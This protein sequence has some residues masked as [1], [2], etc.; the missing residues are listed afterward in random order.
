MTFLAG[1][2]LAG[3]A[4]TG[5][6]V[7]IHFIIRRKRKLVRWGAMQFL[8]GT[9]PRFRQRLLKL[10]ELLV[11]LLRILAITAL[12]LAFAQPLMQ[13][14]ILAR[15]AGETFLIIDAS[16]STQRLASGAATAFAEEI[17]T[18]GKALAALGERDTVRILVASD[19]PRWLT[20]A[21]LEAT[22]G[23]RDALQSMLRALKP[24]DGSSDMVLAMAEALQ[25]PPAE[26]RNSR[27]IVI[28]SD[29]TERPWHAADVTRWHAIQKAVTEASLPT[30]IDVAAA[31]PPNPETLAN[32]AI[33][34]LIA[35]HDTIAIG[36]AVLLTAEVRNVGAHSSA[37]NE[38]VW[39][40][41]GNEAGRTPLPPLASG[42]STT[43]E[44]SMPCGDAGS[45]VARAGIS[46][47]DDLLADNAA[48]VAIRTL[49]QI[50]IL[51]VD[52]ARRPNSADISETGFFLAALGHLPGVREPAKAQAAFRPTIIAPS[53]LASQT[54]DPFFCIVIADAEKTDLPD[55]TRL[56]THVAKGGGLW[57]ALGDRTNTERFNEVFPP[58]A[59]GLSPVQLGRITNEVP[60][61]AP[62]WRVLPP[63][64]PH[65]ATMLLGDTKQ[66]DIDKARVWRHHTVV[67]PI[68]ANLGVLLAL[69]THA[70]LVIEQAFGQGRVFIQ[71][72]PL[73]RTWNN[74]PILQAYVPMVRDFIWRLV[75]G[76][77][78]RR[79][80]AA[81]ETLRVMA[82]SGV[83][84]PFQVKLPDGQ[85]FAGTTDRG[86]VRFSGTFLPGI[87]QV[88]REKQA[89]EL[90]SVPRLPDESDLKPLSDT[91]R[92]F[93]S[94][95]GVAFG[96]AS[97]A[98]ATEPA[99][100]R[101]RKSIA[102][103]LLACALAFFILEAIFTL[104]FAR[105]RKVRHKAVVL[106][107][108]TMR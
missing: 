61:T 55:A 106:T 36:D 108:V 89:I 85:T 28:I 43:L 76:K 83:D 2:F 22:P 71:M 45:H 12:V 3:L 32:L 33:S 35:D 5:V 38:V 86:Q 10:N 84:A 73:D 102:P 62:G 72:T 59:T 97:V 101:E 31:S 21:P 98:S 91:T 79:N 18:A 53:E 96:D 99:A 42:V 64:E 67:E 30:V 34:R 58:S 49:D 95:H 103:A 6:P 69:E 90:F 87:Y 51:V 40:L 13:S 56:A 16:L 4:L 100:V 75:D 23:N 81:G 77:V 1:G 65:P 9:P 24:T 94:E 93:A 104:L 39:Q 7:I 88:E 47:A 14:G 8:T 46:A 57:M 92:R 82:N 29:A 15:R 60:D 68:P 66:L 74:L 37:A 44:F 25:A 63:T 27:H 48:V 50:P 105:Q 107:P 19:A 20:P 70:P 17:A 41:D 52:G 54:L 78:S 80:L 11:L 26:D